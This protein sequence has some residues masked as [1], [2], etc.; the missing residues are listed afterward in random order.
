MARAGCSCNGQH[1]PQRSY[2]CD[3]A[4]EAAK[5][6]LP[7]AVKAVTDKVR[8]LHRGPHWCIDAEGRPDMFHPDRTLGFGWP[9]YELTLLD[10]IEAE[11]GVRR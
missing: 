2:E 5:A 10:Q 4:T 11:M 6:M 3:F 8:A 9:C 1:D 7:V